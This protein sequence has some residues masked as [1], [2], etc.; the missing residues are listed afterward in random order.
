MASSF[1]TASDLLL[2]GDQ[3]A[4]DMGASN[5]LQ[6]APLLA[7]LAATKAT[8]GTQHK[9]LR[10]ITAPTVGF[11]AVNAGRDLSKSGDEIVT[12][13]LK[14]MSANCAVD[15]A[16]ADAYQ[17]GGP[18]ALIAREMLRHIKQSFYGLENQ[19]VNGT[20]A[21]ATG[22]NGFKDALAALATAMVLGAGGTTGLTSVYFIRTNGDETDVMFVLG[23]DGKMTVGDTFVDMLIDG[24]SK[25]YPAYVTP[26]EGWGGIQ[27]GGTYS[28]ARVCNIDDSTHIVNDALLAKGLEMFPS[29]MMPN[30]IV[31]NRRSRRQL[32]QS[33]QAVST[34]GQHVPLPTEFEGIPLIISDVLTNTE[35][36]VA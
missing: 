10:E 15:K 24:S 22:F 21:G 9:Y 29:D 18:T 33:R 35:T 20:G 31:M 23:Q 27:V 32:Q 11:R 34:T 8:N 14:I 1:L 26:C 2:I 4:R 36:A 7:A 17:K 5:L 6:R 13:D 3:N 25:A 28:L 16:L 19:I 30:L 12:I